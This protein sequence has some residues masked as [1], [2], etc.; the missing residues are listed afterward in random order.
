MKGR[1]FYAC[2]ENHKDLVW[3]GCKKMPDPKDDYV[4]VTHKPTGV[5]HK[6]TIDA[7]AETTWKELEAVLTMKR[8]PQAMKLITRIVGYYS[9]T[10]AWNKSKLQELLD[11]R[12]G[13]YGI[14][15]AVKDGDPKTGEMPSS[16]R[17]SKKRAKKSKSKKSD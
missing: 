1:T 15:E 13:D 5:K 7:L 2:I 16:K 4:V 17:A 3:L 11:R 6:L 12:K 10:Y 14:G 9:F 8:P